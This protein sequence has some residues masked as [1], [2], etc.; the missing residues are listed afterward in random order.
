MLRGDSRA[1]PA[2]MSWIASVARALRNDLGRIR[3]GSEL[4]RGTV[5]TLRAGDGAKSGL[6]SIKV[7][8]TGQVIPIQVTVQ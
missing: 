3:A 1:V 5:L 8:Q 6:L 7:E 2:G 4:Q